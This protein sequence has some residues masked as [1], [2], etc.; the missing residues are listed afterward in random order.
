MFFILGRTKDHNGFTA[1][2]TKFGNTVAYVTTFLCIKSLTNQRVRIRNLTFC[3]PSRVDSNLPILLDDPVLGSMAKKYKRTPALIALR[4]QL[5]R[6]VV[7]LAKSFT[8]KRIKENMQVMRD[9]TGVRHLHR[10]SYGLH[11]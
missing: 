5:Q 4:Y 8:E 10:M 7:V 6:G 2:C 1:L 11:C 3:L 9:A